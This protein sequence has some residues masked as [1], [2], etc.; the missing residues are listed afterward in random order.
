MAQTFKWVAPEAIQT[1]LSTELNALQDLTMSS[2][3]AAIDNETDLYQ[4]MNVEINLASL[5]PASGAVIAVYLFPTLDGT[6]YYSTDSNYVDRSLCVIA[7]HAATEAQRA[8]KEN[9]IIPPLKFKLALFDFIGGALA[10]SGNTLK[11]RRHNGQ[12]V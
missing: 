9:L 3:S 5:T 2:L 11:I 8:G 7:L 1:V 6:N 4:F 10:A 12:A